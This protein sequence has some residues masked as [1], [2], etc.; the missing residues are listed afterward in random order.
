VTTTQ[1]RLRELGIT[2]P[3]ASSPVASY[4]QTRL[5]AI[6]EGRSLIYVAGQICR[7]GS[8]VMAGRCPDEVTVEE[9][10]RRARLCGLAVLS[11]IEQAVGLD[12]VIELAQVIGFVRSVDGFTE[13]PKVVNGASDLFVEV[14]GS[15]GKHTRAAV[16]ANALPL[17]ATVEIAAV[18]VVR[19]G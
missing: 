12:N 1:E 4:V 18:A 5:V 15:S 17:G 8:E 13:Q 9:A 3:S 7:D 2:L 6:G 16:S 11:Q 10:N 19:T 14:F